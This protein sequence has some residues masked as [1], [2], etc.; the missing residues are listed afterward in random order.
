MKD[1]AKTA[2]ETAVVGDINAAGLQKDPAWK[3]VLRAARVCIDCALILF[4]LLLLIVLL[5]KK[6]DYTAEDTSGYIFVL[7]FTVLIIVLPLW[8]IIRSALRRMIELTEA[9]LIQMNE[10]DARKTSGN[11][12]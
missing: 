12:T 1:Q 7:V 6:E 8:A 9:M 11:N 5:T 2:A 3:K 4:G 10:E